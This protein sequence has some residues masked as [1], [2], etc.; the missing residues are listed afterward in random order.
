MAYVPALDGVRALCVLAVLTFHAGFEGARGG[1][2]GVST[3]FTLSGFLV[4]SLLLSELEASRSGAAARPGRARGHV[5]LLGFWRRRLRRLVPAS[6]VTLAGVALVAPAW[7][8]PEAQARL[9]ADILASLGYFVNWRFVEADLGYWLIFSA[10]SWVQHFWS[11]AIEGQLYVVLPV[12]VLVAARTQASNRTFGRLV[13]VGFLA[14][15]AC[16][17][18]LGAD[19]AA[20][21]R[22][23]YGTDTRAPELF[24]GALLALAA[25]H[26]PLERG[27]SGGLA[28]DVA[29]FVAL[30]LVG[31]CWHLVDLE[32]AGLTRGGLS[33]Y[34]LLSV[35]MIAACLRGRAFAACLAW[36]PLVWIGRVSYAVYLFHWPIYL[37]LDVALDA[38]SPLLRL[39]VGGAATFALAALSDVLLETPI[40]RGRGRIGRAPFV[41]A[42]AAM[43][44]VSLLVAARMPAGPVFEELCG[45]D[46]AAA[47]G[48]DPAPGDDARTEGLRFAAFGDSVSFSLVPGFKRWFRHEG[49]GVMLDGR[50]R[51]GCGLIV[52]AYLRAME[53]RGESVEIF[54]GGPR[55]GISTRPECRAYLEDVRESIDDL[56]LDVV[57]VLIGTWD[58]TG[59]PANRGP[60]R[61]SLAEPE[62]Q[63]WMREAMDEYVAAL[64][65]RGAEIVWLTLPR[66]RAKSKYPLTE[67]ETEA[68]RASLNRLIFELPDRWPGVVGVLD[69]AQVVEDWP[70]GVFDPALREDGLHFTNA[71]SL[72][73]IEAGVGAGVI[74]ALGHLDDAM[75]ADRS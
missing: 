53:A 46:P 61:R 68:A 59:L 17:F 8:G 32:T 16:S 26:H 66:F 14:G 29:G 30:A 45:A 19:G 67:A 42:L 43:L 10:P 56:D 22:I 49:H 4:T 55:R 75:D 15:T 58:L 24:A 20:F 40:R 60:G 27:R 36:A 57:I 11:L 2:L 38:P 21:D 74:E 18:V 7:L 72:D 39:S 70:G 12:L 9:G 48:F 73:L 63:A 3:F 54:E 5:D 69:L 37:A 6:I 52:P 13:L 65:A 71:G 47:F 51:L 1:Y 62:I 64:S 31:T 28:L 34:A 23:Y 44:C 33:L 25:R 50:N 41:A 35:T